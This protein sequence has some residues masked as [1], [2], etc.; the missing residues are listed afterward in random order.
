MK[1]GMFCSLL[2][3]ASM[4]V[5][6]CTST[7]K[8]IPRDEF[9]EDYAEALRSPDGVPVY[10]YVTTDGESH[11]LDGSPTAKFGGT[12]VLVGKTEFL[13]RPHYTTRVELEE[14][15]FIRQGTDLA[16]ERRPGDLTPKQFIEA[17]SEQLKSSEGVR[18]KGFAK[19]GEFAEFE[20][21]AVLEPDGTLVLVRPDTNRPRTQVSFDSVQAIYRRTLEFVGIWN[22]LLELLLWPFT[23]PGHLLTC[24]CDFHREAGSD[25]LPPGAEF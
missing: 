5:L 19:R 7:T 20:S 9:L 1:P 14:E 10:S 6:G 25:A 24:S 16:S 2:L 21:R 23:V 15:R 8:D 13:F 3:T 17:Y 18:V 12:V 22:L 11:Y 4:F